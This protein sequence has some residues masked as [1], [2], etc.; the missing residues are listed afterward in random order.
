MSGDK[1]WW[2]WDE[3]LDHGHSGLRRPKQTAELEEGERWRLRPG[4]CGL[5]P[6]SV[7]AT[8]RGGRGFPGEGAGAGARRH[9]CRV[10]SA[11]RQPPA[12]GFPLLHSV[13]CPPLHYKQTLCYCFWLSFGRCWSYCCTVR[14]LLFSHSVFSNFCLEHFFLNPESVNKH[15]R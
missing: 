4:S 1:H 7:T 15:I 9:R 11:S 8:S 2:G 5:T 12:C 10:G 6:P 3:C 14:T 13:W